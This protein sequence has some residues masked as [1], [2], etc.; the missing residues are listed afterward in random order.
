MAV[1]YYIKVKDMP[2]LESL[3]KKDFALL[4]VES[5]SFGQDTNFPLKYKL[6]SQDTA[7]TMLI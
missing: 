5:K 1:N 2:L 4:N 3:T 6:I 7:I